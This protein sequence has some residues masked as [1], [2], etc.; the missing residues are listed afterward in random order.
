MIAYIPARGGSKRIPRKNI[1]PL[2]GRPIIAHVIETLKTLDFINHIYVSTDDYEIQSVAKEY[3]AETG[4]LRSEELSDDFVDLISLIREDVPRF[5][6]NDDDL[7]LALP[8]AAL[9][10]KNHYYEAFDI[11]KLYTPQILM[12][13]IEYPVNPLWAMKKGADGYWKPLHPEAIK[14]RSQDLPKTCVDA[15]LFYIMKWKEVQKYESLMADKL[16]VYQVPAEI[17]VDVDT[18]QDW[19]R[20]EA[21][22]RER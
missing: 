12:S 4:K 8:T 13:V 14:M 20:L 7:L 9:V 6:K 2:G 1:K 18:S 3:G 15:G 22:Y 17:A 19:Q 11:Y 16:L 10:K 21:L 5:A